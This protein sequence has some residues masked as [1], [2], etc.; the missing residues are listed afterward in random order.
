MVSTLWD[1]SS[2]FHPI[3]S[4]NNIVGLSGIK[5]KTIG[6]DMGLFGKE[7]FTKTGE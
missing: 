3:D 1:K 6:E 4:L 2:I 7:S 5:A